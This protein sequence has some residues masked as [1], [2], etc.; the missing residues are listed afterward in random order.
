MNFPAL[1][2]AREGSFGVIDEPLDRASY[3]AYRN[4]F[5]TGLR[6]LDVSGAVW[7]VLDAVPERPFGLIDRIFNRRVAM[8]VRVGDPTRP[9][10]AEVIDQLCACVDADSGDLYDQFVSQEE[11]KARFRTSASPAELIRHARNLG[12][13]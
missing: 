10:L 2:I 7:E 8:N 6:F 13:D 9:P 5:F 1:W 12:A 4:G 3:V 11:L